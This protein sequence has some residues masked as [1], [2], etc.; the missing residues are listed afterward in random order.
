MSGTELNRARTR[1]LREMTI[2]WESRQHHTAVLLS[3]TRG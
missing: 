2:V 3:S 1:R